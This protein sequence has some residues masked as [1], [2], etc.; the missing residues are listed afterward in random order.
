MFRVLHYFPSPPILLL[1]TMP[2][3][4]EFEGKLVQTALELLQENPGIKASVATRQAR[5]L[6]HRVL[7]RLKGIP[8]SSF[9]S[10][11]TPNS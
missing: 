11:S 7:R 2:P 10:A 9:A 6:Y 3:A 4:D 8:R 1:T 5:A